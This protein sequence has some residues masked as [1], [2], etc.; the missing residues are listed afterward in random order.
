[1]FFGD[2]GPIGGTDS[3]SGSSSV[4]ITG[5]LYFPTQNVTLSGSFGSGSNCTQL[6]ADKI[7]VSGSADFYNNCTGTGVRYIAALVQLVE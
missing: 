5:A 7:T 3:F 4:A 2:R 6:I 1:M